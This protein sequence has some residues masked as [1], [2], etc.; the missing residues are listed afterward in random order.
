MFSTCRDPNTARFS[1]IH[2]SIL[3]VCWAAGRD[4]RKG[5]TAAAPKTAFYKNA[6]GV[7]VTIAF[8]FHA[9]FE[10]EMILGLV[11]FLLYFEL[12]KGIESKED[13]DD[14]FGQFLAGFCR[15]YRRISLYEKNLSF[16]CSNMC[17]NVIAV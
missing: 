11:A 7:V 8:V 10:T 15:F 5:P 14:F 12:S 13:L 17:L 3:K 4:L 16:S 2:K 1:N 9:E 6:Q